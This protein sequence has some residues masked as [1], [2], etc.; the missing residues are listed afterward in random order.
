LSSV[1]LFEINA[2]ELESQLAARKGPEGLRADLTSPERRH[3]E[4][5]SN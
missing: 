4:A 1:Q 2:P 5:E 3:L